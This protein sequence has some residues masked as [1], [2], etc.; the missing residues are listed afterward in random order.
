MWSDF[1][2]IYKVSCKFYIIIILCDFESGT[3]VFDDYERG[4][5]C[6]LK[7]L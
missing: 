3:G 5:S 4:R 7:N 1:C 6:T 2:C